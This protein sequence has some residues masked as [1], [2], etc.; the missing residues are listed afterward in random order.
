MKNRVCFAVAV[1]LAFAVCG[2]VLAQKQAKSA[3][4]IAEG[5]TK[6]QG[7]LT[8]AK[9]QVDTVLKSL[10][11]LTTAPSKDILSTYESFAK[12]VKK[13]AGLKEST[14][15]RSKELNADRDRFLKAW[16]E[17]QKNIQNED[18]RKAAEARQ[19]ELSAIIDRLKTAMSAAGE[20]SAPF[21]QNMNDLV[22]FLGNDLSPAAMSAAAPLIGKCD[23]AGAKLQ[24]DLDA[25][26]SAASE[27]VTF[28]EPQG[29]K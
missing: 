14:Q 13:I 16:S 18:L 1:A 15:K 27:L 5:M 10:G 9:S 23:E 19:A 22:L 29:V 4:N 20:T 28:F 8:S 24:S 26:V 17:D 11:D 21:I 25:G 3:E 12:E 2:P 7:N 6:F